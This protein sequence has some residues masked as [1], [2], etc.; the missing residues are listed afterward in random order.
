MQPNNESSKTGLN[1]AARIAHHAPDELGRR[2]RCSGNRPLE[3]APL[4]ISDSTFDLL[5][6]SSSFKLEQRC[7]TVEDRAEKI[8][9]IQ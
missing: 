8:A 9:R 4:Q 3:L 5:P 6:S 1:G 7:R 2:L